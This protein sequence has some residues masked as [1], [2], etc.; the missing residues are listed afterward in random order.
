MAVHRKRRKNAKLKPP[1]SS[2]GHG[3]LHEKKLTPKQLEELKAKGYTIVKIR[4]VEKKVRSKNVRN[5][6]IYWYIRSDT[7]KPALRDFTKDRK[8]PARRRKL[9]HKPYTGD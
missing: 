5:G 2:V 3:E 7:R 9:P 8:W 4:G 1:V 6:K